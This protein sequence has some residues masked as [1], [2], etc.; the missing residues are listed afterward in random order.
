MIAREHEAEA[1]SITRFFRPRSVAIVG[2]SRRLDTVGQVL[3]R[4]LINGGFTGRVYAVNQTSSAVSGMPAYKS[5]KDIPDEVDLAIVAVPA[6]AVQ[7]VVLDC[8]AVGIPTK[9]ELTQ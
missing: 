8:A 6:E 7:E 1:A 5:V 3:V 2:A 9:C 4:N